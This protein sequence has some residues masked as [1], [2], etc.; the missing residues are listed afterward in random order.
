MLGLSPDA[1]N[2]RLNVVR[3]MLPD[4]LRYVRVRGLRV[5]TGAVDLFYE[6]RGDNTS[7]V[8]D[9]IRGK[10]DVAF[11]DEWPRRSATAVTEPNA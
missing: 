10:L 2:A 3:P 11:T 7:V 1:P 8:I 9:A 4:W 6:R 5:G